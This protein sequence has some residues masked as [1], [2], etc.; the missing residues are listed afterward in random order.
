MAAS[1]KLPPYVEPRVL[2]DGTT[3]YVWNNRHAKRLGL[4]G[5][6][7][8]GGDLGKVIERARFLNNLYQDCRRGG[9]TPGHRVGT[10]AWMTQ[11]IEAS[12]DH[13]ARPAATKAEVER[14]FRRLRESPL[15][16]ADMSII[17]GKQVKKLNKAI[18]D[19]KGPFV[20]QAT[21]KWLRYLFNVAVQEK[22]LT[23]SPMT[24]LRLPRPPSRSEIWLESEVAALILT[25][26]AEG[27]ASIA[28]AI[29]LAYDTGQRESD[30][31]GR[32]EGKG[33]GAVWR[34][35][36][37]GMHYDHGE[38]VVKQHKT[39]TTV[40]VPALPELREELAGVEK[41]LRPLV[42]C[43]TTGRPYRQSHFCH[44]V[45]DL[46]EKAGF[47]GKTFSDLRRSAVYRLALAGCSVAMIAAITGH[48]YARV[49]QILEVYLPRTTE[50]ARLA[51]QKV[52][53]SRD[54]PGQA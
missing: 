41:D 53:A 52:L 10:V 54:T 50:M 8:L 23:S 2:K 38:I 7:T 33:P 34:D 35:G 47:S 29:R 9:S 13:K 3:T 6:E 39:K 26:R 12:D 24:G 31:I 42:I 16:A 32:Y 40:R 5:Y 18:L 49:E 21:C 46:I 17:T 44:I 14:A 19:A 15:G 37:T 30:V 43:E 27:Y 11:Q 1:I 4:D 45:A 22:A 20:A 28:R 36:M 48:S 51:I 25:A